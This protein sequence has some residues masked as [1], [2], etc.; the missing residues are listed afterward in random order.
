MKKQEILVT[1][2][3]GSNPG[4]Q[5]VANAYSLKV[6]NDEW[7]F[8]EIGEIIFVRRIINGTNENTNYRVVQG[9]QPV[10]FFSS[11][12]VYLF[13]VRLGKVFV[14]EWNMN[15]DPVDFNEDTS[16]DSGVS[17]NMNRNYFDAGSV[18]FGSCDLPNNKIK[19]DKFNINGEI[20]HIIFNDRETNGQLLVKLDKSTWLGTKYPV[21]WLTLQYQN[22]NRWFDIDEKMLIGKNIYEFEN[23]PMKLIRV[24]YES[25]EGFTHT[26]DWISTYKDNF[27]NDV[28]DFTNVSFGSCDG[29][30]KQSIESTADYNFINKKYDDN[31]SVSF[32][33]CDGVNR[34]SI[35]S[36]ADYF[37]VNKRYEENATVSFGSCDGVNK[38]SI[39]ITGE[40]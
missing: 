7:N 20:Y 16:Q 33:S 29:N 15:D 9:S 11:P 34:L 10:A 28:Y 19:A 23:L 26:S 36:T 31:A 3:A 38:L 24:K 40:L 21:C 30:N 22:G 4:S 17:G 13:Y 6:G 1:Q 2:T 18:S 14:K 37:F 12:N 8:F 25:M 39:E 27:A 32:G 35:E 5:N